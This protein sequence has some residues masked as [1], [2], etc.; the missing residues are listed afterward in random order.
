MSRGHAAGG[1]APLGLAGLSCVL[2]PLQGFLSLRLEQFI[3]VPGESNTPGFSGDHCVSLERIPGDVRRPLLEQ[4][5]GTCQEQAGQ[6]FPLP[7]SH[8]RRTQMS[9]PGL[10]CWVL[11]QS[12]A[13]SRGNRTPLARIPVL[14]ARRI[15]HLPAASF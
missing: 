11:A 14:G 7:M 1:T 13:Q 2:K 8:R 10:G 6:T 4:R 5:S 12:L 3:S 15:C 9:E